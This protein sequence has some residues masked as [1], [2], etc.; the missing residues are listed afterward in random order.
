MLIVVLSAVFP[1]DLL[2]ESQRNAM[3]M[4]NYLTV[5][6]KEINDSKNSR[7]YLEE[8]YSNLLNNS[9]PSVID[10]K[11]QNYYNGL[12][13]TLDEYRMIEVKRERLQ[14]LYEQ[15]QA[16]AI[17]SAVPNP[18]GLLGVV[19]STNPAK[20]ISSIVY[21]AVDSYASYKSASN[22][23]ELSYLKDGWDL[24]DEESKALHK[25]RKE[26]FNYMLDIVRQY[27]LPGDLSLT[28]ETVDEF[29]KYKNTDSYVR[30]IQFLEAN[31][32]TYQYYG[33][34]WITLAESYYL[35][36]DYNN[37]LEAIQHYE[38]MNIDIFRYDFEYARV[39]PLAIDSAK[40]I[41]PAD[42]YETYA[43]QHVLQIFNNT[44][45]SDWALRY[46]AALVLTELYGM[47]LKEVY[48]EEAYTKTLDIVNNLVD[49]QHSLNNAYLNPVVEEVIPPGT[50]KEQKKQIE[51][52]NT[53]LKEMRKVETAPIYEPLEITCSLLFSLAD[54]LNVT[55]KERTKID[56]ILYSNGQR[57]FLTDSIEA[58]F[59]NSF[60]YD[61]NDLGIVFGGDSI[62][63]PVRIIG[64]GVSIIVDSRTPSGDS[65][66]FYDW[67]IKEVKREGSGLESY[68]AIFNS[69]S[70]KQHQWVE[71]EKITIKI[72]PTSFSDANY[73]SSFVAMNAKNNFW[74]YFKVWDGY[75]NNWYDYIGVW[76]NS[77]RFVPND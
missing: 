16:N 7:L 27:T 10:I 52:Y 70:I 21:M 1:S 26:S 72:T 56:N 43:Y 17:K 33:G 30:R 13:D 77:I 54:S 61:D 31:K 58:R 20:L 75:K 51:N 62:I 46:Y 63:V 38:E 24:D 57:L 34:Y 35:K 60:K 49:K 67:S 25:I 2:T 71:N 53:M 32:N 19:G 65:Y 73:T 18:V 8:T 40:R 12:L 59:N 41:L 68:N 37:C 44:K 3:L 45:N 55:E 48:L 50:A 4:L 15:N 9:N 47:T 6:T 23:A 36:G 28:E 69:S 29:V 76:N 64:K 39:I 42:Q 11:T 74:D 22:E 5:L 14:Y 66:H